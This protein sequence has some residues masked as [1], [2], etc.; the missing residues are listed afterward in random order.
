MFSTL[1][2]SI[3]YVLITV[4]DYIY[5]SKFWKHNECTEDSLFNMGGERE[6][7]LTSVYMCNSRLY[8]VRKY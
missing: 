5:V 4:Y 1:L 8:M 6:D 7:K 3:Y 2:L